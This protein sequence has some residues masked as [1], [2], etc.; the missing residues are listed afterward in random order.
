M[1]SEYDRIECLRGDLTLQDTDAIVNAAGPSLQGGGGVDGA[2][3]R[4]AGP[5]L[6]AE[7]MERYRAGC[8][9]GEA[10]MTAGHELAARHVIHT[11][12][13][14]WRGGGEGEEELLASCFR[15]SLELAAAEGLRTLSFPAIS[16]GVYRFPVPR[17]AEIAMR[18]VGSGLE[19]HD[20]IEL[21]R[22]VLF[23]EQLLDVFAAALERARS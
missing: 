20:T 4:A 8:P 1:A 22:F 15:S 13:P 2:I 19:R 16:C 5:G 6:L 14:I 11:V 12:G 7:C 21:V 10:R 23:S 18:E 3:H 17:A 9:T